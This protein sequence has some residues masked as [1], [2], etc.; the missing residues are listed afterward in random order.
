[1][2][3][4]EKA[5][6]RDL[7]ITDKKNMSD[8]VFKALNMR[9]L[10]ALEIKVEDMSEILNTGI[11]NSK[12]E[13]KGSINEMRNTLDGMNSMM[14]KGEEQINDLKDRVLESNQAEQERRKYAKQE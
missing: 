1:M 10:T 9:I 5:L 7:S 14:E 12:A 13:L 4:Q 2:K 11:R 6:A 3:E 8:V